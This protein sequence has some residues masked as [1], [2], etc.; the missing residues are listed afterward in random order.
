MSYGKNCNKGYYVVTNTDKYVGTKK[1]I[2]YLSSYEREFFAWADR[3]RAVLK[4]SAETVVVPYFNPIKQR[5]A[6]YIVDIYIM[7]Q[8]KNGEIRHELIEIKPLSMCK[9]PAKGKKSKKTYEDEMGRWIT[10]QAKWSAAKKY[11]EER[12]WNF[13]IITENSIFRG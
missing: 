2:R 8:N 6:R 7:Y 13:R 12:G 1:E 9:R 4:W 3:C 10:N 5:N 11:A